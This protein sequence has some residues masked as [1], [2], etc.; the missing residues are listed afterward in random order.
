MV[1]RGILTLLAFLLVGMAV[2]AVLFAKRSLVGASGPSLPPAT[3]ASAALSEPTKP[4]WFTPFSVDLRDLPPRKALPPDTLRVLV[5]GDSVA[6]FLGLA[7]RYRQ[8]ERQTFVAE[9]GVG[10]CSIFES[11]PYIENGKQLM[12][13]SCSMK[14]AEDVAELQPDVTLVVMGGGYFSNDAC[15]PKFQLDYEKRVFELSQAMGPNAG[16]I[17]MTRVPY[18]VKG[19]RYANVLERVDC[20]NEMLVRIA[21]QNKWDV[22]DLMSYVCPSRACNMESAGKPIRPDGLHFDGAGAED[23]ARWVLGDLWRI[24]KKTA[25]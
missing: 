11:K 9:R 10:N 18:P 24:H 15:T 21:R 13:S 16:Q 25:H 8:D 2:L 14:W 20:F 19:W 6:K 4:I 1:R 7:M 23:T 3:G 22:L 17:V 5:V 12:S